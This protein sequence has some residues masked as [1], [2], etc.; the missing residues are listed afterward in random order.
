MYRAI[1]SFLPTGGKGNKGKKKDCNENGQ[2]VALETRFSE[3]FF[4]FLSPSSQLAPILSYFMYYE[5]GSFRSIYHLS[6]DVTTAWEI[7]E[8]S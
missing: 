6:T 4:H 2:E 5:N 1:S 3:K 8:E 7:K